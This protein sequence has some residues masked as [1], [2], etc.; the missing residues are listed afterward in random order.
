M[1]A[2]G[3]SGQLACRVLSVSQSGYYERRQRP[4]SA[5]SIRPRWLT[6]LIRQVHSESRGIYGAQ[7]IHAELALGRGIQVSRQTVGLLMARAQLR[8]ISG[9]P[10][11]RSAPHLPT[12]RDHFER[13]VHR[14]EPNRLWVANITEHQSREGKVFC[15]VVLDVFSRR[16]VGWAIDAAPSAA[17]TTNA[18]AMA[19]EQRTPLEGTV[20]HSDQGTQFTPWAFTDRALPSSLVPSM[21][22]VGDCFDCERDDR[23]LLESNA[24]RAA[25]P[26]PLEHPNRTREH[27]LR[28]HR[29][30]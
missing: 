28:I 22:S 16:V 13:D 5:R 29:D 18:L 25:R 27:D 3:L 20:I 9:R 2:E 23:V 14:D 17:L 19:I 21:G 1:A 26:E 7:G 8:G 15:A 30:A 4:A 11:Y 24:G 10:R 12:A 6:E